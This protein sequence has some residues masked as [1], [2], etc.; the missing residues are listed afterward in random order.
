MLAFRTPTEVLTPLPVFAK[1]TS[2]P[3]NFQKFSNKSKK[4]RFQKNLGHFLDVFEN[5]VFK[6]LL[7]ISE[8]FAGGRFFANTG[9]GKIHDHRRLVQRTARRS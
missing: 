9:I 3:R 4:Q 1:K 8:H 5:V 6:M 7:N 2:P